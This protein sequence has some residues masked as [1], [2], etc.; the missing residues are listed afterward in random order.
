M[1]IT[2]EKA[3]QCEECGKCFRRHDHLTVHYKSIHLGE[4]VWQKYVIVQITV[5][6]IQSFGNVVKVVMFPFKVWKMFLISVSVNEEFVPRYKTA[7]HQC[8]VCK[9]EFKGKSSLEM[10]F[11]THSGKKPK[12]SMDMFA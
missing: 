11:R 7:V 9:K 2:G 5:T 1:F 4:K 10:H 8:E 12:K 3:H 6:L